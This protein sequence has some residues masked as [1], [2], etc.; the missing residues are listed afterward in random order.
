MSNPIGT[1][2]AIEGAVKPSS[3]EVDG[4]E[5]NVFAHRFTQIETNQQGMFDYSGGTTVIYA[6][7]APR[8]LSTS[9][10]GWLLQK[11][12]YDGNGNVTQRQIAYDTWANRATASYA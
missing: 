6:G 11:F 5:P 2:T 9:S 1:Q 8:G 3:L 10:S 12:T 4:Y 7:Y